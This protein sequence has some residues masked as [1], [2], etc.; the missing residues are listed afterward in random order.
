VSKWTPAFAGNKPR[1][2][3]WLLLAA[4]LA[5]FAAPL[6]ELRFLTGDDAIH[7]FAHLN[8]SMDAKADEFADGN[9]R[10]WLHPFMRVFGA[11]AAIKN[12]PLL[13]LVNWSVF[14]LA[15]TLPAIALA[16]LIGSA[17][18]LL[19]CTV[20]VAWLVLAPHA[21]PPSWPAAMLYP[22]LFF[23]GTVAASRRYVERGGIAWAAL[24]IIALALALPAYESIVLVG[25]VYVA[26]ALLLLSGHAQSDRKRLLRITAALSTV[27]LLYAVLYIAWRL[28]SDVRYLGMRSGSLT[29]EAIGRV[30]RQFGGSAIWLVR[31]LDP[32]SWLFF[33]AA[34]AEATR[35]HDLLDRSALLRLPASAWVSASI[36]ALLGFRAAAAMRARRSG[37]VLF[38][39]AGV[40]MFVVAIA[41]QSITDQWQR[42]TEGAFQS[43]LPTRFAWF[44]AA[45]FA[46]ALL[47]ALARLP[48]IGAAVVAATLFTGAL[49][50]AAVNQPIARSM[51]VQS[52]KFRAYDAVLRCE[53]TRALLVGQTVLAPRLFDWVDYAETQDRPF[54]DLWARRY[55]VS[56][57][58]K[59]AIDA[60]ARY[61]QFDLRLAANGDLLAA[62]VANEDASQAAMLVRRDFEGFLGWHDGAGVQQR[63]IDAARASCGDRQF[64]FVPLAPGTLLDT[65]TLSPVS[66]RPH[67]P[68]A[69]LNRIIPL[70]R[71]TPYA[72]RGWVLRDATGTWMTDA[73]G[74][75]WIEPQER[76]A[77]GI[78]LTLAMQ[79]SAHV[80]INAN[81]TTLREL[82]LT[83]AEQL[84]TLDL[85]PDLVAQGAIRLDVL[86]TVPAMPTDF[87]A[88]G[89]RWM[90]LDAL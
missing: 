37:V 65:V 10:I 20:A 56:L 12:T 54:F 42:W 45:T 86:P 55:G 2:F 39:L 5:L 47:A 77:R 89:L 80:Q 50:A 85:A 14:A 28:T 7:A 72:G 74:T 43:W 8:G 38:A 87:R 4:L 24:A 19:W 82:Q 58:V 53:G 64:A 66:V 30:F 68:V 46:A 83:P 60:P 49:G 27:V 17:A 21:P 62:L 67:F 34:H 71:P 73:F 57:R 25:L 18:A 61:A 31:W 44:G 70:D 13:G 16:P 23:A 48:R 84:V 78:R 81:G 26:T 88:V 59:P 40:T 41:L 15:F 79:G 63:A 90:R 1:L 76:P 75:L 51:R 11:I 6:W 3:D 32:R 33:D 69:P 22:F 9:G 52:A 35:F 29:P 36:A